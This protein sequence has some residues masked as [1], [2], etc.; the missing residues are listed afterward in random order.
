VKIFVITNLYPPGF[1]G[2]YELGAF[3]L[4]NYLSQHGHEIEVLTSNHLF[5]EGEENQT[6]YPVTRTLRYSLEYQS[7][8][9]NSKKFYS[10]WADF[11]NVREINARIWQFNPDL[12]LTFNLRGLGIYSILKILRTHKKPVCFY[13]M[14]DY[15]EGMRFHLFSRKIVDTFYQV[16][17][18]KTN[19]FSI[20]MSDEILRLFTSHGLVEFNNE[21]VLPGWINLSE[22]KDSLNTNKK[23]RN[24]VFASRISEH[25]G[26]FLLIESLKSLDTNLT[27]KVTVSI[28]GDGEVLKIRRLI[29]DYEI[30]DFVKY[31]G[32]LSKS[33]LMEILSDSDFLIFPTWEKETFGFIVPEALANGCIPIITKNAAISKY[34]THNKDAFLID[35]DSESLREAISIAIQLPDNLLLSMKSSAISTA[36]EYFSSTDIFYRINTILGEM[37]SRVP[38]DLDGETSLNFVKSRKMPRLIVTFAVVADS[39]LLLFIRFYKSLLGLFRP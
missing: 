32:V 39:L 4:V 21:F 2:G 15:L 19:H 9:S 36:A 18:T 11:K 26:V 12:I 28:Y 23:T 8:W 27:S 1:I 16:E 3:E 37:T 22:S 35:R 38:A 7:V 24:L 25:K 6:T 33:E 5:R 20:A 29:V 10:Y 14:D 13:I 17:N 31:H 30:Q 34:L